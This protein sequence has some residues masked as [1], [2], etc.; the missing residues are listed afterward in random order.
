[1]RDSRRS[2]LIL[3]LLLLTAFTLVTLDYRTGDRS[4]LQG[5]RDAAGSVFGPLQRGLAAVTRPVGDAVSAIVH[6]GRERSRLDRLRH[7]NDALRLQ[8]E[9]NRL[10][11]A[12]A[13]QLAGLLRLK[14]AGQYT[15]VPAQVIA[16]GDA[17]GFEWT[18][19]IDAGSRDGVRPDMTVV[20]GAGLVGRVKN[21]TSG[22]ATVLLANDPAFHAGCR[23]EGSR[24]IG[25]TSGHGMQPMTVTLPDP[26]AVI[27]RGDRLVTQ[28][29]GPPFAAGV[30]IGTVSAVV[31]TPGALTRTAYVTPFVT[32]TALDLVGVVV[33]TPRTDP[34]D[35]VLPVSPK[36]RPPAPAPAPRASPPASPSPTGRP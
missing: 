5:V 30:P 2:R 16:V 26:R 15:L 36:P 28:P 32:F 14:D 33:V 34:R 23:L 27:R 31:S 29:S 10:D 8:L 12:R 17:L 1:M 3:A 21:V 6:P 9:R 20:N 22:T 13:G 35:R 11:A 25:F 4:P 24:E 18:A 19:T 7:E